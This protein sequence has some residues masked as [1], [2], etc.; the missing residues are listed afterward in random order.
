MV[1]VIKLSRPVAL[2][3]GVNLEDFCQSPPQNIFLLLSEGMFFLLVF[4]LRCCMV[5]ETWAFNV[6][7]LQLLQRNDRAIQWICRVK[8]IDHVH[9]D[10]LLIKLG[11]CYR[12]L[13]PTST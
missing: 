12:V 6:L 7:G 4:A 3:L 5:G 2:L 10:Q 13:A 8:P 1:G 9:T 11:K